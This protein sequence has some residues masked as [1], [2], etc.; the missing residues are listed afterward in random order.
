MAIQRQ[1][2]RGTTSENN[3]FTGAEGELVQDT[4]LNQVIVH[5]GSQQGGYRV[6]N[7]IDVQKN[8]FTRSDAVQDSAGDYVVTLSYAPDSYAE[9]MALWITPDTNNSGACDVDVNG[10][11]LKNLQKDDGSGTFI[12]LDADDLRANIPSL[13]FYDG[14]RFVLFQSGGGGGL[15][16]L[17]TVTISNQANVDITSGIDSTYNVY[18]IE[19]SNVNLA[20]N[21]ADLTLQLSSDGGSTFISTGSAY[22]YVTQEIA[23]DAAAENPSA[24]YFGGLA[25]SILLARDIQNGADDT[26]YCKITLSAPADSATD[27]LLEWTCTAVDTLNGAVVKFTG[28]GQLSTT[29]AVNAVR[30]STDGGNLDSGYA[31]LSG[32][33]KV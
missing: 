30:I 15:K 8:Y 1:L 13:I 11:G 29:V 32:R 19:L 12:E 17:S 10:L 4:D 3:S 31:V 16:E 33:S 22:S 7:Y 20:T 18:E 5:D 6:P 9:G 27:C 25:T 2:R 23:L 21:G 14:F 26:F 28:S 24:S